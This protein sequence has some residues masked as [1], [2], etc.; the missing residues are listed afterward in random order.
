MSKVLKV[1]A[2][3]DPAVYAYTDERYNILSNFKGN[4]KVDFDIVPFTEYY[5]TMIEAFEGK[6]EYDIV[7]VA[8]HLWMKDF[9]NK[10]YLAAVEKDETS[11]YGYEDILPVIRKEIELEGA[12]YLYPSFC[13]GHVV[14]YRKSIVEKVMGKLPQKVMTTDELIDM[15]ASCNGYNTMQGIVLKAHPSEIF[16]DFIPYLR[17]EGI[18][19]INETT[20]TPEFNNEKGEKA[21]K[22]YL[23]LKAFAP[24]NTGSFGNDEVKRAFQNKQ[25]VF[26]VTWG[27][28]LG[29]VL[30]DGCEDIEDIGFAALKTS[31]NVTWSFAIN[32]LSNKKEEAN[33]FLKYITSKEVDRIVGGYAGSPVRKSS[34]LM[35]RNKYNWYDMHLELIEHYA[36]PLPQLLKAG[37]K[38]GMLYEAISKTF[39]NEITIKE[40]L[41]QA[42]EKINSID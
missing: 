29:V 15:A 37:D 32:N 30:G 21:L 27:G 13:D 36:R 18:E 3:G 5:G 34:Y 25:S 10:G 35:D 4:F 2:V 14:L 26:A 22:K 20:L 24:D 38:F 7:M 17:N 6:R 12:Q 42:E 16:L 28:Q 11:E 23:S 8:G 41:R 39:N 9:I 19:V 1:L 31:W 40:C 33:E